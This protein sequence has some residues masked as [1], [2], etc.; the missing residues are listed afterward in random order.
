MYLVA[1]SA[2][3]RRGEFDMRYFPGSYL[4][5]C[6]RFLYRQVPCGDVPSRHV[7]FQPRSCA[8]FDGQGTARNDQ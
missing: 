6:Q 4:Q 3:S 5:G 2:W 8:A 1:A 7:F